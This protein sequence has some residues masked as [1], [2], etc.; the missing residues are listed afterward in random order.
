MLKNALGCMDAA[1]LSELVTQKDWLPGYNNLFAA[2]SQP[3][4]AT[5]YILLGESPYPRPQSA[6]G[7]AF[8]D[9][10]VTSLWSDKGFSKEVNRATSL[11]NIMKMLLIARG[12][13]RDDLSQSA[14][15]Q[16]DKA[17][18]CK[19]A[20]QFFRAMIRKGFL[21]LNATLVFRVGEV[22][23]H[24]R[25]WR[26][27]MTS[28]FLQLSALEQPIQ[29]I[30]FGKIAAEVPEARLFECLIAEHPYNLSFITNPVVLEFFKPLDLLSCHHD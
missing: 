15:A 14:I 2:F 25:H 19:T 3:L 5:R 20:E 29:F 18:Y 22:K 4:S 7:Y 16:L 21:L 12:D 13:L 11:R 24:A 17:P 27:F 28:L 6:N 1:Y 30:L 8:W 23:Y 26:P 9:E 10:A